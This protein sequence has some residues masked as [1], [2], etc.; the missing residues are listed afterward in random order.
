[1]EC[2]MKPLAVV[3]CCFAFV[4]LCFDAAGADNEQE[5]K[6]RSYAAAAADCDKAIAERKL[7][8]AEGY[9]S[10]VWNLKQRFQQD[11]D[12]EKALAADKEW[13]RSLRREPLVPNDLVD[14]PKELRALQDAYVD[15]QG[16]IEQ[17]V[18]DEVVGQLQREATELAKA[19]NLT[20]GKVLQHEI[21]KIKRLY[22]S[23]TQSTSKE[24]VAHKS[25]RESTA[26]VKDPVA[27]CEELIR[28]S[29]LAMQAQY[30]GELEALEKSSQAKGTRE[31]IFAV[32]A[33]RR[34]YLETPILAESNLVETPSSLR[35]LQDKYLSLQ[36]GLIAT[37]VE[38][39]VARLEQQ[40]QSL[41]IEGRLE[42]A[43]R[44]K[45]D[46]S[47]IKQRYN[48][49]SIKGLVLYYAFDQD[50]GAAAKDLSAC[51]N[52]GR[53][54]GG[55][56][57][58]DGKVGGAMFFDGVRA[59][60][61]VGNP[62]DL[63]MTNGS[64][65]AAAWVRPEVINAGGRIIARR[66]NAYDYIFDL[67]RSGAGFSSFDPSYMS[68]SEGISSETPVPTRRWS[69]IA[70]VCKHNDITFYVNGQKVSMRHR[71]NKLP[72]NTQSRV[73]IGADPD[74]G[75]SRE[76]SFFGMLDEVMLFSRA[77]NDKEVTMIYQGDQ[78]LESS[79]N[80]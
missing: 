31:D 39:I 58:K 26:P 56:W 75:P 37:V 22:L 38:E 2:L 60:I 65:S 3:L 17:Q 5:K 34:R 42:E 43:L 9:S 21:D 10:E 79:G 30:V 46:A 55:A 16:R 1:M 49:R 69:H 11:G 45:E 71:R 8:L 18:A 32:K 53:V 13:S 6:K 64:L 72:A 78:G 24:A 68:S 20:D 14:S 52:D 44:A 77:L 12:L 51:R 23:N 40:K 74:I 48:L 19:G 35:A 73:F 61:D 54:I 76:W 80:P 41:T 29:R 7:S 67:N 36:E 59:Y 70:W 28:T 50:H 62:R 4:L 63:V 25:G 27:A 57:R 33:E 47:T 66:K 15:R